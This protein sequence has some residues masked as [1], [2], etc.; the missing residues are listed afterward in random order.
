MDVQW[1]VIS[2]LFTSILR[3]EKAEWMKKKKMV[4]VNL[5]IREKI[6]W[7]HNYCQKPDPWLDSFLKWQKNK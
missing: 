4:V 1:N 7:W 2:I 3:I 5:V 6:H